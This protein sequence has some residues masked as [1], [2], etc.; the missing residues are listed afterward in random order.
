[1]VRREAAGNAHL[2]V[3]PA[4]SLISVALNTTAGDLVATLTFLSKPLIADTADPPATT[5][6]QGP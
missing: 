3:A 6:I 5:A 1:M 4:P 2:T